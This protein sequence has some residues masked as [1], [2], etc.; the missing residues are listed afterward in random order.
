MIPKYEAAIL[1]FAKKKGLF[2]KED[3]NKIFKGE[4]NQFRFTTLINSYLIIE[5]TRKA[6]DDNSDRPFNVPTGEY[7]LSAEAKTNLE[8]YLNEHRK[9]KYHFMIPVI[10]SIAALIVAIISLNK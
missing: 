7:R 9:D 10:I 5:E 8:N 4:E 1:K 6:Y 2:T 3:F